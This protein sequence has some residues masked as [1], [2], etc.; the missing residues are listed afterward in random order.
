MRGLGALVTPSCNTVYATGKHYE[1]F[2]NLKSSLFDDVVE[3]AGLACINDA[4]I[5]AP[6]NEPFLLITDFGV[7]KSSLIS[8][9]HV[10][11]GGYV[12]VCS[13]KDHYLVEREAMPAIETFTGL[14]KKQA[15]EFLDV[16]LKKTRQHI[17]VSELSFITETCKEHP[18]L[19]NIIKKLPSDPHTREFILR[20]VRR[21][22]ESLK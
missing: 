9:L 18:N 19:L 4:W 1:R 6:K 3:L 12:A 16:L 22:L 20:V 17:K 15:T 10:S 14:A 13:E 5:R 21:N 7:K 2:T 11:Q 8:N